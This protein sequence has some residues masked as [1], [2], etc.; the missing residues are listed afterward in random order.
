MLTGALG[1]SLT[2]GLRH[3][4]G[5]PG[6]E[7]HAAVVGF[8]GAQ[9]AVL[10]VIAAAVHGGGQ[11]VIQAQD[12]LS[13]GG[14]QQALGALAGVNVTADDGV[15]VGEDGLDTVGENDL[16]LGTG[17]LNDTLVI[18]HIV[19][20]GE[21]MDHG[22]EVA[23]ELLQGQHIP[24]GIYAGLVQLIHADQMVAHLIGGQAEEQNDLLRAGGNAGEQKGETVAA[25]NGEGDA[26]GLAAGLGPDIRSD[27]PDG[28]VVT[29]TAGHHGLG[30]GYYILVTGD[31][32]LLGQG[33]CNGVGGYG[34]DIVTL[35]ENGGAYTACYG[36]DGSAHREVSFTVMFFSSGL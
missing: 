3:G 1:Q 34:N 24:E 23:A 9:E 8:V 13:A 25:E 18:V 21:G 30:D 22:A 33:V 32:A 11:Q 15:G 20:A 29:L 5:V 7:L 16:H 14:L 26:H 10:G 36:T 6:E 17:L 2:Q 35:T 27:L 28:S 4:H 19:N 31:N 12:A